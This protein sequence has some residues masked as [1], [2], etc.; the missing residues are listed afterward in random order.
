MEQTKA[1]LLDKLLTCSIF[2]FLTHRMRTLPF[3]TKYWSLTHSRHTARAFILL[4][5]DKLL[6][7]QTSEAAVEA[8]GLVQ[9][10]AYL[11]I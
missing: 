6:S 9:V 1:V 4:N 2:Y 8:Q 7:G 10:K 11:H 5:K 3:L